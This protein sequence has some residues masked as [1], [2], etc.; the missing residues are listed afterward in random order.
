MAVSLAVM[1]E[2]TQTQEAGKT[3][4]KRPYCCQDGPTCGLAQPREHGFPYP[5]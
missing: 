4:Q 3:I 2:A 5:R 1:W